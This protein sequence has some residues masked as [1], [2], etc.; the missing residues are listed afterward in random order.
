[1]KS[2]LFL[3]LF[4]VFLVLLVSP[5][6]NAA[7]YITGQVNDSYDGEA[8]NGHEVVLWN[9]E[10]GTSDNLTDVIGPEGN[11]GQDN[12]Y[13][14]DCELLDNGCSVGD[15]LKIRVFDTG[16]G[17]ITGNVS[18]NVTG[19]G[20]DVA[21][22]LRLNS[23]PNVTSVLV[24][25]SIKTPENEID[26]IA[27]STRKVVCE[28]VVEEYDNQSLNNATA[29]FF[30]D[31]SFYGDSDDNNTHYTNNSCFMNSSY[32]NQGQT[33]I[34]CSFQVQYY[35]NSENW[36]CVI[37]AEDNLSVEG[38]GSD[39]TFIN[40]LLSIGAVSEVGF[41][42]ISK[43]T[44]TDETVLNITNY[45]NVEVDL[46]LYGYGGQ[47]D[48]NLSMTCKTGNISIDYTK[49][50]L[51]ASN[52]G[53]RN[54]SEIENFYLNLSSNPVSRDFN[55]GYR[56]D[57]FINNAIKPTYWRVYAPESIEGN[58]SGNIVLGAE[59]L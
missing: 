12:T 33:K 23:F 25:D 20:Y 34:N 49:Y 39:K 19:A 6:L 55:L 24:D 45:G 13:M 29:R 54:L 32:G 38:N 14:I 2:S 59:Q 21:P 43:G 42:N 31:S 46:S 40:S 5:M 15:T 7:H 41:G 58:C 9:S 27:A 11:S 8:A 56:T 18:L 16:D 52:P 51:T 4:A 17:Y 3:V 36:T 37:E 57:D 53:E 44:V 10:T 35:A 26:L 30:A 47:E 22:G 50:N 28:A 1:M 48:D